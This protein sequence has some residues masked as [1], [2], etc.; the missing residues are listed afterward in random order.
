MVDDDSSGKTDLP[1]KCIHP[2]LVGVKFLMKLVDDYV[3][4][5]GQ[6]LFPGSFGHG[7]DVETYPFA[8]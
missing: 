7:N 2:A 8:I 6:M 1:P 4:P 5:I 3:R